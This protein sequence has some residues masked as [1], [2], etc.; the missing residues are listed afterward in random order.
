MSSRCFFEGVRFFLVDAASSLVARINHG[1]G[2][3]VV[4]CGER[5][6][7]GDHSPG[8][9]HFIGLRC[10]LGRVQQRAE[11]EPALGEVR[12]R[13][14]GFTVFEVDAHGLTVRA[15]RWARDLAQK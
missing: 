14:R 12:H 11:A 1:L 5:Q 7:P 2:Q 6:R 3:I 9:C 13:L 4:P 15:M 8:R 10:G